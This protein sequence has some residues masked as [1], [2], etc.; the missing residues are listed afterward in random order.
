MIGLRSYAQRNPLNEFKTEAFS[1]FE[2]LMDNLRSEVTRQLMMIRFERAPAPPPQPAQIQETHI[3]PR[4][5]QN[6]MA[7]PDS[8]PVA[9][10]VAP[11]QRRTPDAVDPT[12]PETWGRVQRNA[13]CP[14]GSGK[15]YKH[16]HG[17][18]AGAPTTA[19]E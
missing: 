2:R 1:L 14:C 6:E 10:R 7:E 3:D 4:T 9:P 16:C 5:G 15:K 8:P 13:P 11:V 17:A 18:V 12:R 19:G